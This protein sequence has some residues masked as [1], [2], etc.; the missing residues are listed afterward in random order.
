VRDA[1]KSVQSSWTLEVFLKK[2]VGKIISERLVCPKIEKSDALS[3]RLS[4]CYPDGIPGLYRYRYVRW[5]L[6]KKNI[7][8]DSERGEE[9]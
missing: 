3:M 8:G 5:F 2:K 9:E 6:T 4:G 1:Q 7:S